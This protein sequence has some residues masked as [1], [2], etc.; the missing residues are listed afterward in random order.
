[1]CSLFQY[2]TE[3]D[4]ICKDHVLVIHFFSYHNINNSYSCLRVSRIKD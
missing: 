2:L 1:M 4:E 3:H